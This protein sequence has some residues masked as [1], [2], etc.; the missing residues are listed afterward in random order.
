[1]V[2]RWESHAGEQVGF[3]IVHECAELRP[4]GAEINDA[5]VDPGALPEITSTIVEDRSDF[6][7]EAAVRGS[8]IAMAA[9]A[10][11]VLSAGR[12]SGYSDADAAVFAFAAWVITPSGDPNEAHFRGILD[13]LTEKL[14]PK[15]RKAMQAW[16]KQ[17]AKPLD[18]S[19]P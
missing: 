11:S 18:H 2:L 16:F 15:L 3:G 4:S 8:P 5:G 1:M 7:I 13:G 14:D 10:D 9:F 12:S 17:T 6:M 19:Y